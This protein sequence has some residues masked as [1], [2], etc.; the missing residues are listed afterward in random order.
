MCPLAGTRYRPFQ[1]NLGPHSD[2]TGQSDDFSELRLLGPIEERDDLGGFKIGPLCELRH[3][4]AGPPHK[5]VKGPPES[6][7]K[8][9]VAHPPDSGSR[10]TIAAELVD[11]GDEDVQP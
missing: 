4:Q 8:V 5:P 2:R 11:R 3:R 7:E 6:L 1:K 9:R 10:A